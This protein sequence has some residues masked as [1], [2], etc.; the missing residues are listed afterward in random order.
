MEMEFS[1]FLNKLFEDYKETSKKEKAP[2]TDD[3]KPK[4]EPIREVM[5]GVPKKDTAT[6]KTSEPTPTVKT[7]TIRYTDHGADAKV[8]LPAKVDKTNAGEIG[9]ALAH[10]FGH[11]EGDYVGCNGDELAN[12]VLNAASDWMLS[13][14]MSEVLVGMFDDIIKKIGD[15]LD[16]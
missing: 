4:S 12:H 6:N 16:D 5:T 3:H 1:E 14:V 2:V 7:I 15:E 9:Y 11:V 10:A 8:I 13:D